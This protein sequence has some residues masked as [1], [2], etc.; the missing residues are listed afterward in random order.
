[1]LIWLSIPLLLYGTIC[2]IAYYHQ[3]KLIFHPEALDPDFAFSF[4]EKHVEVDIKTKDNHSLHALLFEREGNTQLVVYYHGNA[5]NLE[6]WG[7][8]APIYLNAGFNIIIYDYRGFGK[9]TGEIENQ[10]DLLSDAQLVY[11]FAKSK[12]QEPE[13]TVIGYSI[14]S[15]LASAV[16]GNNSPRMLILKSPYYALSDLAASKMPFLPG[17]TLVKY[18]LPTHSYLEEVNFPI[19]IFHGDEDRVIPVEHSRRLSEKF[20]EINYVELKGQ[21]HPAMN[22]NESYKEFIASLNAQVKH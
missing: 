6:H 21:N 7:H 10:D 9:S 17:G 15:G 4:E 18:K 19:H 2:T 16:A 11:D 12:Y 13:I 1:M 14:G 20:P 8:I 5:G 22:H 3:E